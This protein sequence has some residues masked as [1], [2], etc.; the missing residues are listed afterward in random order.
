MTENEIA[1]IVVDAAEWP[2]HGFPLRLRGFAQERKPTPS[3]PLVHPAHGRQRA[4]FLRTRF[5][6]MS[7]RLDFRFI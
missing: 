1:K 4:G 7:F 6:P 2:H 3:W 5:V